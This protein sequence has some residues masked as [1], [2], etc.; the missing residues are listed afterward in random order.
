MP[1]NVASEKNFFG[2]GNE[3]EVLKRSALEARTGSAN[4]IFLSGQRGI[5][6][7]KLLLHL[8]HHLFNHQ[9]DVIPF[10]YTIKTAY[11]SVENFAED[12]V[13]NFVLQGLAFRKKDMPMIDE[14]VY[15]IEDLL[16]LAKELEAHWA[17]DIITRYLQVKENKSPVNQFLFAI[18]TP[19]RSSMSMALPVVVMID[20][21]HKIR[22]FC[23]VNGQDINK[24]SWMLFENSIQSQN[25][26]HIF[27]G[28]RADLDRMFFEQT[29]FGDHL[30]II[31]VPGLDRG[32]SVKLFT[33]LSDLYGLNIESELSD[34]IEIFA[35]N[36]F[37]IKNFLQAA[38]QAG[39]ALS[40][41]DL[42]LIYF[43]EVTRGKTYKYWTS[44]LKTYVPQFDLRKPSLRFL[45]NLCGNSADVFFS[46]PSELLSVDHEKLEHIVNLLHI[47]GTVESGFSEIKIA[48]DEILLD[49]IRG[50]YQREIQKEPLSNIKEVIVGAKRQ[51]ITSVKVPAFD[52]KIPA[53]SKAELVAVNSIDQIARHFKLRP[54]TAG[55]IQVSLIELFNNVLSKG[56]PAGDEYH[57][58]FKLKENVFFVESITSRE[59]LVLTD[60]AGAQ[61]RAYVD[62]VRVEKVI[63][64]SKITMTKKLEEK[65]G[66]A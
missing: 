23:E 43:N 57:L 63:N 47:S 31:N 44:L 66:T 55:Q 5:G 48:D 19:G 27:S 25:T 28:L 12:Y 41:E 65:T 51:R 2:R 35:G 21:F 45:Y 26:P 33:Y 36:P 58:K 18:S 62:D 42:W 49:V 64:G 61:L 17:N 7:T 52:I 38:R 32:N 1:F 24:D 53:E 39:G 4:S 29:S 14:S 15:S 3:L 46:N 20:D 54:E 16:E 6:K 22:K 40:E 30:E 11:V 59:D 9:S 50:L 56:G 60:D 34:F 37:Y 10:F 8:F 13:S